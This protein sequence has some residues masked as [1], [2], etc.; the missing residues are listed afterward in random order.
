MGKKQENPAPADRA[1]GAE[2]ATFAGG[3]FWC[4]EHAFEGIEGVIE[5]VSGYTGG[6]MPYPSYRD[7]STGQ[8]GHYEAVQV[9]YDPRRVTYEQ[10]LEVFWRSIDPT[11]PGGQ[12][13][14]RGPQY[15]TAIFYHNETQKRLA[16]A[17]KN[18]LEQMGI[19]DRPIV[20]KILPARAFYPA[21]DYHQGYYKKNPVRYSIYTRASGRED[22]LR[23]LWDKKK[24][25]SLLPRK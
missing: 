22:F 1:S 9:L 6:R 10:L 20:T 17:S 11:D 15:R 3:C 14:D 5:A 21:E 24:G 23:R 19:F 13:A 8:T 7:V 2:K 18:A 12:F 4:M 16:E 25:I